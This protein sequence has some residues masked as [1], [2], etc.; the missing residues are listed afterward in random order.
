VPEDA[1][2]DCPPETVEKFEEAVLVSP[3]LIVDLEPLE[4]L[5]LPKATLA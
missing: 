3:P 1:V 2:F 4:T 5:P